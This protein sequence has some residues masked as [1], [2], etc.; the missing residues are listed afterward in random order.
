M[1]EQQQ[2]SSIRRPDFKVPKLDEELMAEIE[3][4][5]DFAQLRHLSRSILGKNA[6][7]GQHGGRMKTVISFIENCMDFC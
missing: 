1:P 4:E 5:S 3:A 2:R 7:H 6:E